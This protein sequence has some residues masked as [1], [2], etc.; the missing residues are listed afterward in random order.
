MCEFIPRFRHFFFFVL[1]L[2]IKVSSNDYG[3]FFITNYL[4]MH[5]QH[6]K[7][8]IVFFCDNIVLLV[9]KCLTSVTFSNT[10][11]QIYIL[12]LFGI[13]SMI[14]FGNESDS[15]KMVKEM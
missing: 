13:S 14:L 2:S 6:V 3:M 5:L 7:G 15:M 11:Y 8:Q 9:S 10:P 12:S 4:R 1:H